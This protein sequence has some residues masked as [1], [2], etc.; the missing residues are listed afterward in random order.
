MYRTREPGGSGFAP[1]DGDG[2]GDEGGR[3]TAPLGGRAPVSARAS[4][5]GPNPNPDSAATVPD[6]PAVAPTA[7]VRPTDWLSTS[8]RS[9]PGGNAAVS[10]GPGTR[11]G[12]A[13]AAIDSET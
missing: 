8:V 6:G 2:G 13:A 5:P 3:P 4:I 11:P 10:P 1:A 7:G 9:P 12:A